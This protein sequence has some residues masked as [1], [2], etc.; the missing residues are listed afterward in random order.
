MRF[1]RINRNRKGAGDALVG[2]S[3]SN[4]TKDFNLSVRKQTGLKAVGSFGPGRA[5]ATR[6]RERHYTMPLHHQRYY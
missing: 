4:L 2:V 3:L 5:P 6:Q 1:D